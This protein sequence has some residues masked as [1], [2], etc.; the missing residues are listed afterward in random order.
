MV[1]Q[2]VK[3]LLWLMSNENGTLIKEH[4]IFLTIVSQR[5]A[6][7]WMMSQW[8]SFTQFELAHYDDQV[9]RNF[10]ALHDVS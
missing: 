2:I 9:N 8:A 1:Y 3:R 4:N 5:Q 7:S 6:L 10:I